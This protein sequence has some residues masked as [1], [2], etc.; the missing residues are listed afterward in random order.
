MAQQIGTASLI[1][2]PAWRTA[3][4]AVCLLGAQIFLLSP[5]VAM[6]QPTKTLQQRIP[7]AK[8]AGYPTYTARNPHMDA[9][10]INQIG[11][12]LTSLAA[13]SLDLRGYL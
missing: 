4:S 10:Q 1:P 7:R 3:R 6:N 8:I 9:E 5:N 12:A 13:R 11:T 2:R